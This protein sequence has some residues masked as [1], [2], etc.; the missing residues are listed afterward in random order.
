MCVSVCVLFIVYDNIEFAILVM[1]MLELTSNSIY[2]T[3]IKAFDVQ[4]RLLR[5]LHNGGEVLS[6]VI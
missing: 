3:S 2:K 5:S 1:N 4:Q 6:H